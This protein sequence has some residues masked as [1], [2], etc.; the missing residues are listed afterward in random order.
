MFKIKFGSAFLIVSVMLLSFLGA[1]SNDANSSEGKGDKKIGVVV[2]T[3]SN[4]YFADMEKG[5]E[6]NAEDHGDI[7]VSVVGGDNDVTKQVDAINDFTQQQVDALV[8]Q[9]VDTKGI[10]PAI[11]EANEAGIPVYTTG[12]TP[13]G[14]EIETAM[15]FD[16]F[17]SGKNA[18]EFIK[19]ELEGEGNVVEIM[20][21]LGQETSQVKSDGFK[22]VI[23]STDGLELLDS[24]PAEYDRSEALGTMEDYL[25][26][27]DDIDAVYAANDEMALGA[28]KAIKSANKLDD[29]KVIGNDGIDAAL[30]SIEK[31][32]LTAT[33]AITGFIQG[34]MGVDVAYREINGEK[35]PDEIEEQNYMIS[36]ENID[37]TEEIMKGV[38]EEQQYWLEERE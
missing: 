29:I 31:G 33:I 34:D 17:E 23:E 19:E 18:G 4:S 3:M 8:V 27:F 15:A 32:E 14:G 7:D 21:V 20:G 28:V 9:A 36:A 13:D 11:N 35:F 5:A 10:V 12:E 6:K 2:P 22:S 16:N 25:Q 38:E 26:K 24:Q 1:C 30:D 37:E